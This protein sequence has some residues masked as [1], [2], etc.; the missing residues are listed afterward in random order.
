VNQRKPNH[1]SDS[2]DPP[3]SLLVFTR[4]TSRELDRLATA[5]YGIPSIVLMENAA[6]HV[7][8]VA[9]DGLEEVKDPRVLVVCGPGKNG[10][11]GLAAARHLHN[12]GMRVAILLSSPADAPINSDDAR[13]NFDI[14]QRMHLPLMRP[15]GD[16]NAETIVARLIERFGSPDLVIDALL[17]TG[18]S[19]DLDGPLKALVQAVNTLGDEGALVLSVDIPSGLDADTGEVRGAAVRAGVTVSFAGLKAGFLVLEA[20][21]YLGEVIV[22]DIGA[23]RELVEQLGKRLANQPGPSDTREPDREEDRP[24]PPSRPGN[25]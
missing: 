12:A 9:V 2:K 15:N 7:A 19:R 4:E 23:P 14:I 25:A 18:L 8:D 10:G 1:S 13:T 3:P 6:R 5:R 24:D 16:D 11:D 21:P 22:A 20:Q 17:G